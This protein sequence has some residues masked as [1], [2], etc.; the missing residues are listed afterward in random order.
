MDGT[1]DALIATKTAGKSS[2]CISLLAPGGVHATMYT[3]IQF[4]Q[5]V[6]VQSF[7]SFDFNRAASPFLYP[8]SD[9]QDDALFSIRFAGYFKPTVSS[10]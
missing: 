5:V 4:S 8:L 6:G 1:Y 2:L 10:C 9:F 3:D 7:T